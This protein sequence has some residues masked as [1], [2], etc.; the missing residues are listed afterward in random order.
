MLK[1]KEQ[2]TYVVDKDQSGGTGK[3]EST[4]PVSPSKSSNNGRY[5]E[6]HGQQQRQVVLVLP[7]DNPVL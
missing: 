5:Q 7:P 1:Q 2:N 4:A 6:C 3:E